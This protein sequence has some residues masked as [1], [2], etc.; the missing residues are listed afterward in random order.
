MVLL[1]LQSFSLSVGSTQ[2][3][4]GAT[5]HLVAGQR[6]ALVGPNGC[7]K[8]TLLRALAQ[9]TQ[10]AAAAVA[11]GDGD[12]DGQLGAA[13]SATYFT[14]GAGG[15]GGELAAARSDAAA[16]LLVE[17]DRLDWQR[18]LG[19]EAGTEDELRQMTVSE[20]L[21][22]AAAVGSS[23]ETALEDAEGWRRLRVAADARLGWQTAG[24]DTTPIGQLSP[25]SA[26]RA[27]LALALRR[28]TLQLLL[29]DE[30]TNHLDLPSILWLQHAILASGKTVVF[31]SHDAAFLDAV[32]EQLWV[33]DPLQHTL[34]VS[35]AK[36]TAFC[37]AHVL[38]LQQQQAAHEAQQ[39]RHKR[40]GAVADSLRAASAAGQHAVARD[41]DKLQRDFRRDRAGRSG[42][43]AKALE[44]R[45]QR[46]PQV[47]A[48]ARREPLRILL[49]PVAPGGDSSILLEEVRLGYRCSHEDGEPTATALELPPISLRI[50]YGERVAIVGFNG[51]GKSTLLRTI[52]GGLQPLSGEVR[53]GRALNIGNLTQEHESLPREVT[54][55]HHMAA[56]SGMDPHAA[57]ARLIRYGLTRRQVDCPLGQLNPG[58]RARA[59]LAS[60]NMRKVNALV[61][62]EP[63]NHLDE[64]AVH[65]VAGTL[66]DYQGTV[67]VVSHSRDFLRA[68]KMTRTL[69]LSAEGGLRDIGSVD[70]FVT[71][72]EEIAAEVVREWWGR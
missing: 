32:A 71:A 36:Y 15:V 3:L 23:P 10:A 55:R 37:Q 50:D 48:V 12:G 69:L 2:L 35:G 58:A 6:V 28:P 53:L 52:L 18:L 42:R 24:Y 54:P 40:L 16:A 5:A 67:L 61:L 63:T 17:Q 22:M 60:F 13:G 27:Y 43:K 39:E 33:L 14:Q 57:G 11:G 20:A 30:P 19:A 7:G 66:N 51:V 34:T 41:N 49:E 47:E 56:L 45:L 46:E 26:V 62:D 70:E 59:L 44:A 72:T 25:G 29:L 38:A 21:D 4:E 31:V 8:S 68:V 64:E 9:P 1:Q 65:E